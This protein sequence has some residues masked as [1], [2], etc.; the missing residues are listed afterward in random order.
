MPIT[1]HTLEYTRYTQA[2]MQCTPRDVHILDVVENNKNKP[3]LTS[4][5]R[6]GGLHCRET[7]TRSSR[8]SCPSVCHMT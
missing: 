4:K 6:G 5:G 1:R 8:Q 7:P 3:R 2:N